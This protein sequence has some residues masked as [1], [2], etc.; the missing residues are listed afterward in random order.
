MIQKQQLL[1]L[2]RDDTAVEA[3][4]NYTAA[5]LHELF[6]TAFAAMKGYAQNN[7]HH[8][9]DLLTH[10]LKV[11]CAVK[12]Q[13]I[14]QTDFEVLRTAALFHD[15]GKPSVAALAVDRTVYPQH[16][17]QSALI[18]APLLERIGFGPLEKERILFFVENH[19]MFIGFYF[20]E[21]MQRFEGRREINERKVNAAVK[22]VINRAYQERIYYPGD[23]DFLLLL[24]LCQADCSAQSESVVYKDWARDSK[25]K[26]LLRL[27]AIRQILLKKVV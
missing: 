16:A 4:G 13:G 20:P 24:R 9:Y 7:P 14:A 23:A 21:E 22:R 5:Q 11:V 3:L 17:A 12:P 19:D 8:C 10:T 2:L 25:E 26:K 1:T 27:E 15:I 18:T 6:G